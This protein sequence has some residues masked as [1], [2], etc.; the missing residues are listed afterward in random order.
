[1][2]QSR[3]EKKIC[4]WNNWNY[5]L[6]RLNKIDARKKFERSTWNKKMKKV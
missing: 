5:H 6:K 1:M 3:N 2:N 4:E